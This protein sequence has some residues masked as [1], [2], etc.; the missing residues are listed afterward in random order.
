M[1]PL[2][3]H[4]HRARKIG[5]SAETPI[6]LFKLSWSIWRIYLLEQIYW[7]RRS[8]SLNRI[9]SFPKRHTAR[10]LKSPR[11]WRSRNFLNLLYHC[12]P[13][14][15]ARGIRR[16]CELGFR[17]VGVEP[18]WTRA[19]ESERNE[20]R[21]GN[22]NEQGDKKGETVLKNAKNVIFKCPPVQE[23]GSN[24]QLLLGIVAFVRN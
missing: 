2:W 12:I 4:F 14:C 9:W 15:W 11:V 20:Q 13:K 19:I 23:S 1:L 6:N 10:C 3:Q 21:L 17:Q 7:K 24:V 16:F 18:Y 22:N 5:P 8:N